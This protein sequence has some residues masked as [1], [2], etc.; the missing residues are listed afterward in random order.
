MIKNSRSLPQNK[1]LFGSDKLLKFLYFAQKSVPVI[2]TLS[3]QIE[4]TIMTRRLRGTYWN[5]EPVV[6]VAKDGVA[7]PG[8]HGVAMRVARAS[9]AAS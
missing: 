8:S 6:S 3:L 9:M 2:W 4:G 1:A 5:L 7:M